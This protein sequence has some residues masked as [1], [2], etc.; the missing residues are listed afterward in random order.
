M[1]SDGLVAFTAYWFRATLRSRWRGYLGIVVLL[2]ITGG[3]SLFAL[4]GARRTQSAYPRFLRDANVSTMAVDTGPVRPGDGGD[5]RV[6]VPGGRRGRASTSRPRSRRIAHGK[7]VVPTRTSRRWPASTDASSTRT[8][9]RPRRAGFPNPKRIDEVAVNEVAARAIRLPARPEARR[10]ARGTRTTSAKDFFEHPTR[11]EAPHDRDH[12]RHRAVP[13]G[14]RARRHRSLCAGALHARV[15]RAR[16]CPTCSTSG[17]GSSCGAAT[18]TSTHSSSATSSLLDPG[19]PQFFRVTSVTTFHTQQAVRPL[20]IA[21]TLFGAIA[22]LACVVLVGL[23]LSRQLRSE[24]EERAVLRAMGAA[25]G[26]VER[27]RGRPARSSAVLVGAASPSLLAVAASPFM[28]IGK[29]R[30][31]E[32]ARGFDADWTVLGFGALLFIALLGTVVGFTAWRASP[33]RGA[34]DRAACAR[35]SSSPPR[36]ARAS[37]PPA[38]PGCGWP[39][40][41]A[42]PHRGAGPVGDARRRDRGA[43]ARRGDDVREQP[44]RARRSS[45]PVRLGVGRHAVDSAG[46]GN[47]HVSTS[48]TRCSTAI[49]TSTPGRARSSAPT[50]VDGTNVPLLGVTPGASVHPPI[51]EGR[52]IESAHE[53]VMG[54]ETLAAARQ[55]RRRHRDHRNR[56]RAKQ[57]LADRRYR[58]AS[59]D[60]HRARRVHIARRRCDGRPHARA[61]VRARN[62]RTGVDPGPNVIFVRF[63]DGVDHG[64]DDRAACDERHRRSP[65]ST[66]AIERL[67]RAASGGDRQRQRHRVVTDDPRRRVLVFAALASLALT[68][69][70]SVRRRRHDLA[71]LKTLGFT[72]RQLA[73]TVRWQASVTVVAGLRGRR[74]A[75][76][77]RRPMALGRVRPR[78]R[79]RA[80]PVDAVSSCCS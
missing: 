67:R 14:S 33:H 76:H 32:V 51:L 7:P 55:A 56:R 79:R 53:V 27:R 29:V 13:G 23:A 44:E 35:R 25:P 59:H 68:L 41:R 62:Y 57:T 54:S 24:P 31:V 6:A 17:R 20:S 37:P 43:R 22:F 40:N 66:G 78:P 11:T 49:R 52:S 74:A 48:R 70:S 71:L 8:A 72:R 50:T 36:R 80:R 19:S 61:R 15:H 16:R 39:W 63:R 38:S 3:L 65:R 21:L 26:G 75:R 47:S 42:R 2:G 58:D 30:A 18:P 5:D 69:G 46:Y 28:P 73:A 45:A 60:R 77:H 1:R 10:S 34:D 9:S 64:G 4:A 12:R